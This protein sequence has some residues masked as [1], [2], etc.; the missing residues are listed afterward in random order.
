MSIYSEYHPPKT[1]KID[2]L[3]ALCKGDLDELKRYIS[4]RN[5]LQDDY[6]AYLRC[7]GVQI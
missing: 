5:S 6:C 4:Q 3:S 1:E 2:V 7:Q